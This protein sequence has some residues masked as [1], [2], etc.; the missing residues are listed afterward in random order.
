MKPEHLTEKLS[1]DLDSAQAAAELL[2]VVQRLAAWPAPHPTAAETAQ[3][4]A[5]LQP[6]LPT[7]LTWRDRVQSQPL[8]LLLQAQLRVVRSE[9][10]LASSVIWL[11]GLGVTLAFQQPLTEGALPFVLLAPLGAALGMAFIYGPAVDPALE[12]ELALPVSPRRVLLARFVLVFGLNLGLGLIGSGLLAAV[13]AELSFW[14]LVQTWLAPMAC[15]SA[16]ALLLTTLNLD[17][18][19]GVGLSMLLWGYQTLRTV[20]PSIFLSP[21][22]PLLPNFLAAELRGPLLAVACVFAGV[23]FWRVGQAERWLPG[24]LA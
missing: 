12:L 14:P 7:R 8:V 21:V 17:A 1:A 22:L 15:L 5:A 2:P 20:N 24:P 18:L 19:W 16:L 3:L 9:I 6:A 23:A 10:W 11:L 13:R 4:L